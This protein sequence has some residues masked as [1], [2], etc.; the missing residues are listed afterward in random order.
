MKTN[1]GNM[2]RIV[3][4]LLGVAIIAAGLYFQNWLGLIGVVLIGTAFISFCP[5]YAIF[6]ISTCPVKSNS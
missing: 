4:L 6:G 3:R 1:V 5:I 2:D